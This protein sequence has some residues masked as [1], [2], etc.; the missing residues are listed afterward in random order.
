MKLNGGVGGRTTSPLTRIP[1]LEELGRLMAW[2]TP[3]MGQKT[4]LVR[5]PQPN[6]V[7]RALSPQAACSLP[8]SEDEPLVMAVA[9]HLWELWLPWRGSRAK[10]KKKK[11]RTF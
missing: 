2:G 7:A 3:S 4:L 6:R 10:K 11:K 8:L 1:P 5:V 9:S